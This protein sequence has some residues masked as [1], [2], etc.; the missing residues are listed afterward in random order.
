MS[1][2]RAGQ[3]DLTKDLI[4][5]LGPDAF[6]SLIEEFGGLRLYVD[7]E[8]GENSTIANVIGLCA[9]Q[10]MAQFY[11]SSVL[12]VPLAREFRAIRYRS[13]GMS[14]AAIA[15]K[16]GVTETSIDKM[17]ERLRK[18]GDAPP[19]ERPE[20]PQVKSLRLDARVSHAF[21]D[22]LKGVQDARERLKR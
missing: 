8:Q 16:I 20:P 3:T 18:K 12:R 13:N 10:K 2:H 1:N 5:F 6:L 15:K 11:G 17:F 21:N 22:P 4:E 14:Y 7:R 9:A 19:S